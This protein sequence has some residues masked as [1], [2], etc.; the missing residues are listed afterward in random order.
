MSNAQNLHHL[1]GATFQHAKP[2]LCERCVLRKPYGEWEGY[3]AARNKI[4]SYKAP[5]K[6]K[7]RCPDFKAAEP[8]N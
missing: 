3:C 8:T 2:G 4:L 7:P 5:G 1:M 6:G